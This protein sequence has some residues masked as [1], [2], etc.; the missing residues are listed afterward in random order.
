MSFK[1][2]STS[3]LGATF[4]VLAAAAAM[5]QAKPKSDKRIPI[6]KEAGGEVVRVDTVYQRDTITNTV[7]RTDTLMRTMIRI[8]TVQVQPP[9]VPIRLPAGFYA[10]AAFGS[11]APAGSIHTPNSAGLLGQ[12][13]LGWQ[14]AKQLFGGRISGTYTGLGHDSF[15]SPTTNAKLWTLSTDAKLNLPLGHVFGFTPRLNAY[16]IGG[17]TYTWYRDM[18]YRLNTADDNLFVVQT[19][20]DS[21]T[22]RNGWDAGG[23]LSLMWNRSEVFIESRVMG[24]TPTDGKHAYQAPFVV[25]FNWY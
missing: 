8:D 17:W 7:F 22:G 2:R 12:L 18:P 11:S 19:G 15:F 13:H 20:Q 24:F 1:I 21:W 3:M 9:A 16:G 4:V 23:G 10:G 5:A 25:G 14:N 6:A